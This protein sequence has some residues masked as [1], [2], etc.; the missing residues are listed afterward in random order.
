LPVNFLEPIMAD[1][2]ETPFVI[3]EAIFPG[4]TQLDFTGPHT[5]F[6]RMSNVKNI[7]AS[8]A[9]GA[10]ESDGGLIFAGTQRLADIERCD[11]LFT[12]GGVA[13]TD[14]MNDAAF[15]SEIRRLAAGARY[16][17]SVCTGSLIL[18][19]AGLLQGRK[20]ACHW[21]WR[22]LLPLFGAVVDDARVVRD[23]NIITGGGV[24]A[25]IDL[26][27][28][29]AAELAGDLTAQAI[30][31]GIEYAPAPPFNAGRPDT[32]PPEVLAKVKSGMA[33][34]TANRFAAAEKA[35]I[36]MTLAERESSEVHD[37]IPPS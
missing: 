33:A 18:A 20:S 29:I 13:V 4:V 31:L 3:V 28:V 34:L 30:Q 8:A 12:P 24:T 16:L 26:A 14:A 23:G 32:A 21:A 10:I 36:S 25:G 1:V 19:A 37:R 2:A 9:G 35:A 7:V 15:M 22:E 17:T 6:S 11:L 5:V 27:L